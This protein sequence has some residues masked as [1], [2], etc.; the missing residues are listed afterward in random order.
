[1]YIYI[2]IYI[3]YKYTKKKNNAKYVVDSCTCSS[4]LYYLK[5]TMTFA[6]SSWLTHHEWY[7]YSIYY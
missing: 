6:V 3:R 2:Y 1:M 4:K 7:N 5:I